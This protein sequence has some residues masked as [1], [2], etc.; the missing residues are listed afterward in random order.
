MKEA[1]IQVGRTYTGRRWRGDRKVTDIAR[2][3]NEGVVVMYVDQRTLRKGRARLETFASM[4][5]ARG[6]VAN[7]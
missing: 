1:D 2:R 5:D 3:P 4:A 6:M 7:S